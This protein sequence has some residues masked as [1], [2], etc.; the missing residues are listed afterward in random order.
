MILTSM[1]IYYHVCY[2]PDHVCCL[3]DFFL[4]VLA[5]RILTTKGSKN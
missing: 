3:S 2:L 1:T 4:M 5:L